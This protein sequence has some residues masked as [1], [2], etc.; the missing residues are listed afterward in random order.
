MN[1]VVSDIF[2]YWSVCNC[3]Y[4]NITSLKIRKHWTI[5]EIKS[6]SL[7][8]KNCNLLQDTPE[9]STIN[10]ILSI[11]IVYFINC[12]MLS[13]FEWRYVV[14]E[15][16]THRSVNENIRNDSIHVK[17]FWVVI[18]F[19]LGGIYFYKQLQSTLCCNLTMLKY[20]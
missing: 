19:C 13:N 7:P 17:L 4:N 10:A 1:T 11:Q 16:I 3:F 18:S 15:T 12:S 5:Y 20:K 14:I 9:L 6:R 2:V 8:K